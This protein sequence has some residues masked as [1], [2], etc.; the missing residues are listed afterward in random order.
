M[1][2]H[3]QQS[4]NII[5]ILETRI[6]NNEFKDKEELHKILNELKNNPTVGSSLSNEEVL[7]LL[8]L[9]DGYHQELPPSLD[10]QN[11]KETKLGDKKYTVATQTNEVLKNIDS[12][13]KMPE[14]FKEI[15]NKISAANTTDDLANADIVF[16]KMKNTK[17]EELNFI[18]IEEAIEMNNIDT[19]VLNKIKRFITKQNINPYSYRV[20]P[21]SGIFYNSE[22]QE[23]F[24][25]RKNTKIGEYE[26]Y[27]SGEKQYTSNEEQV[28]E[29]DDQKLTHDKDEEKLEYENHKIKK[30]IK[31][32]ENAAFV[33]NI[34]VIFIITVFSVFVSLI[35]SLVILLNK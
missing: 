10:L 6:K 3:N 27:K 12:D 34:F 2:I 11:Y 14:E 26:I 5:N 33:N 35:I 23:M 25:V 30:L 7:R 4:L 32:P 16:S 9:Y 28:S 29:T 24:E 18:P 21:T 20:N 22:T 13:A 1:E 8:N 17:K 19:E 31:P 15:Q